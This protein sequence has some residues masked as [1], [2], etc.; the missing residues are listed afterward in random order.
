MALVP[1]NNFFKLAIGIVRK[2]PYIFRY[3]SIIVRIWNQIWFVFTH[4]RGKVKLL[5]YK[6]LIKYEFKNNNC[7]TSKLF[8]IPSIIPKGLPVLFFK[9]CFILSEE[10][11]L[12]TFCIYHEGKLHIL[13]FQK[14]KLNYAKGNIKLCHLHANCFST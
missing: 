14:C 11:F 5:Y 2:T 8:I 3:F 10:K 13:S 12:L 9:L 6:S 7:I 4:N 1:W